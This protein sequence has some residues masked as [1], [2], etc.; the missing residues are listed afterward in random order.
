MGG[1]LPSNASAQGD[2]N[3]GEEAWRAASSMQKVNENE[4]GPGRTKESAP[5]KSNPEAAMSIW[6]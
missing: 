6:T 4:V 5:V 2:A 3:D 1:P